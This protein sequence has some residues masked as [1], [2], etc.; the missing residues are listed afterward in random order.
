MNNKFQ[1]HLPAHQIENILKSSGI[2]PTAQRIAICRYVLCE[3]KHFTVDEI[4]EW[5]DQNFSKIS[6]ATVYNTVNTLVEAGLVRAL[7][8]PHSERVIYDNNLESHYHF[9]DE[10][11]GELVDI[12]PDKLE[13]K[14]S[15][16]SEFKINQVDI[17][18]RG[19]RG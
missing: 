1:N 17:L 2:Q 7:K 18:I 4:K 6:L 11:T 14:A 5:A 3:A 16:G 10:K 15:L 12:T 13:L 9:L 19:T 8:L